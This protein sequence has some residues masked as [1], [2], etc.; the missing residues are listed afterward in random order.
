MRE[1]GRGARRARGVGG[2]AVGALIGGPVG[3][4][5]G[6]AAGATVLEKS[7]DEKPGEAADGEATN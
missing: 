2:A 3:A 4:V 5:V 1:L 6:G 7:L